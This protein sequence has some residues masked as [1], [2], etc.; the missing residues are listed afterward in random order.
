MLSWSILFFFI[1]FKLSLFFKLQKKWPLTVIFL[2]ANK[3]N[4]TCNIHWQCYWLDYLTSSSRYTLI[5]H[6]L[7]VLSLKK[8]NMKINLFFILA[9]WWIAKSSTLNEKEKN[10]MSQI[11]HHLIKYPPTSI[12]RKRDKISCQNLIYKESINI[13]LCCIIENILEISNIRFKCYSVNSFD[14]QLVFSEQIF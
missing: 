10:C 9:F 3:A 6:F 2:S 13:V 14:F 1:A 4:I 12:Y 8:K 5:Y 7:F 11:C